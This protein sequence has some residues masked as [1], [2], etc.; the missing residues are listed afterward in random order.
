MLRFRTRRGNWIEKCFVV[1][2]GEDVFGRHPSDPGLVDLPSL[3]YLHR[4]NLKCIGVIVGRDAGL[5]LVRS[6]VWGVIHYQLFYCPNSL[7]VL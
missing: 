1:V 5:F 3:G 6:Q 2:L 4:H 7:C